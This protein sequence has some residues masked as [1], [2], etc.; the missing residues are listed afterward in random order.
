M[1]VASV[2]DDRS[3]ARRPPA[4]PRRGSGDRAWDL[5]TFVAVNAVVIVAMWF[6]HGDAHG[7]SAAG[8]PMTAVGQLT[9]LFGMYAMLVE[10]VLM[11]R[12]PWLEQKLGFDRLAAWH[13]WTGFAVVDLLVVH[14]ITITLGYAAA[15]NQSILRQLGDFMRHYPD[16]LMG[17]AALG[18]LVLVAASS[19]R[20]S[21][22][23]LVRETWYSIHLYVYLA[24]GLGFAHQLAVGSDFIDDPVA[25]WWWSSLLAV[26][27]AL[28][29]WFRVVVP[30]AF[31]ARHRFRI[32]HV[33]S[34]APGVVSYYVTGRGMRRLRAEAGQFF[35]VRL[36]T[37]DGW[38]RSNPFSLSAAP[39]GRYLRFT[40]KSL[41]DHTKRMQQV[42]EGT[43]VFLEGP[44]GTF[45][46][47][48]RTRRRVALIAGGIGITPLR[49]LLDE[50]CRTAGEITLLYRVA[51]RDE[52]LFGPELRRYADAGVDVRILVDDRI[53]D[54]RTDRL[55][56]PALREMIP[57]LATRDLY[58][59]GPPAFVDAIVRRART[60]GVASSRIHHE[61]FDY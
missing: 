8:G 19:V 41:G 9:G 43:P 20:E 1:T 23:R 56:V 17:T 47:S 16:V 36:L 29:V 53:G 18:L 2:A 57:D 52:I 46:A 4:R 51:S 40:I 25:R 6:R 42:D 3:V 38:W 60:I 24:L 37:P 22:R 14:A 26:T 30:V 50:L 48:R 33:V 32:A 54:D 45:T 58:L 21:R 27:V 39:E 35:M 59:C 10:V 49:A 12:V 7:W 11:A 61:K 44:L 5:G 34:E 31:N 28:V 15:S 13:R 55:G